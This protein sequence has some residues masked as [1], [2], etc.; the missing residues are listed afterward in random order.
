MTFQLLALSFGSSEHQSVRLSVFGKQKAWVY[1]FSRSW[2]IELETKLRDRKKSE[3]RKERTVLLHWSR[4]EMK[5]ATAFMI[6]EENKTEMQ[7]CTYLKKWAPSI[8]PWTNQLTF[9]FPFQDLP[10]VTFSFPL[11]SHVLRDST[12]RCQSIGTLVDPSIGPSLTLLFF[13]FCGLWPH[14]SIS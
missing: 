3:Q 7:K 6:K 5:A 14:C 10:S 12:P 2:K 9:P 4:R 1:A 13:G 11:F 8:E